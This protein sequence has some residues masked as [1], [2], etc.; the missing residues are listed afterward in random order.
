MRLYGSKYIR[1][2][3][4][5]KIN[6]RTETIDAVLWSVDEA[7]R[8][9][10]VKI[11]GSNSII[12]AYYPTNWSHRP[13]WLKE[14][15]AVKIMHTGGNRSRIEVMGHGGLLPTAVAGGSVTPPIA[16]LEDTI[17]SGMLVIAHS[18][19]GMQVEVTP[20][21]YRIDGMNY[22]WPPSGE[23]VYIPISAA[24]ATLFRY[25]IIVAGTNRVV[26][27]VEGTEFSSGGSVPVTPAD[28]LY[29]STVFIPPGTISLMPDNVGGR[30][31]TPIPTSLV[32]TVYDPANKVITYNAGNHTDGHVTCE[33]RDQYGRQISKASPGY[34]VTITIYNGGGT[35]ISCS[36]QTSSSSITFFNTNGE[37]TF[38]IT[39]DGELT[40][41]PPFV[42][43]NIDNGRNCWTEQPFTYA[44]S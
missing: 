2:S 12:R 29:L 32:F 4:E 25:D 19:E 21:A 3:M 7:G 5:D 22:V 39:R 37:F 38:T 8:F 36:G 23:S 6:L 41:A 30:F 18:G 10:S 20:G 42:F 33:V 14:G 26:D 31:T 11:Q 40:D 17:L 24:D 27:A 15:N 1:G 44:M 13:E 34:S 16:W 35:E 28:H 43:V 9:C